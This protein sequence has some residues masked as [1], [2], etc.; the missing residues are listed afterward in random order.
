MNLNTYMYAPK[1]DALHRKLWRQLYDDTEKGILHAENTF[2]KL[3]LLLP[4]YSLSMHSR[5]TL[6]PNLVMSYQQIR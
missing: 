4:Y 6:T 3:S 5:V 1:D 2:I